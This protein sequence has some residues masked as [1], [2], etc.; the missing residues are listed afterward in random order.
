VTGALRAH[1]DWS[2]AVAEAK[3]CQHG[4]PDEFWE[5]AGDT[6]FPAPPHLDWQLVVGLVRE[7]F[8]AH[9]R[10]LQEGGDPRDA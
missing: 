1:P 2:A 10:W 4:V 7:L 6:A 5:L 9:Q 3:K 8:S